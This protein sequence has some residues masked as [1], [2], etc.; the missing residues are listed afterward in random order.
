MYFKNVLKF[1]GIAM[2]ALVFALP[3][4]SQNLKIGYVHSQK[5]LATYKDALDVQ[6]KL[7]EIG[8]QWENEGMEMQQKIQQLREQYDAQSLLLSDAKKKEKE[9]EIQTMILQLQKFQQDKFNPQTGEYYK[10]QAELLQP[11]YDRINAVIKKIGDEEKFSYI[12]DSA[13]GG[14]VHASADQPDLTD[15]V[16]AELNKGQAAKATG[17]EKNK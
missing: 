17:S 7:D 3:V 9:Q 2:M 1:L 6:K 4:F 14:I 8:R 10:K 11:V 5:I 15:R 12:F 13:T 16:L